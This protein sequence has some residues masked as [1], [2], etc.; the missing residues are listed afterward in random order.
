MKNKGLLFL[1]VIALV[2]AAGF[3][4]AGCEKTTD[5]AGGASWPAALMGKWVTSSY[6]VEFKEGGMLDVK[7]G[8]SSPDTYKLV[9][10]LDATHYRLQEMRGNSKNGDPINVEFTVSGTTLTTSGDKFLSSYTKE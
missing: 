6:Y 2:V 3:V 4:L 10:I 8:E 9:E 5:E 7:S 1:C